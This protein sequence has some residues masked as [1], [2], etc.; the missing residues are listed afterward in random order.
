MQNERTYPDIAT[1]LARKA[2]GRR[3][4]ASLSFADKRSNGSKRTSSDHRGAK[5]ACCQTGQMMG[6]GHPRH[7]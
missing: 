6:H 2:R 3:E 1:I 5:A 7:L 4:R